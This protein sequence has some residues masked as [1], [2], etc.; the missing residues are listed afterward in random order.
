M[1]EEQPEDT[2]DQSDDSKD[3]Q[4]QELDSGEPGDVGDDQLP[5]DLQPT[6]DNPLARHPEQTGDEDDEIGADRE[7]DPDTAPLTEEEADYGSDG[8]SDSSSDPS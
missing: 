2:S 7:D 1:S 5:E 4:K 6:E 3:E 8:D